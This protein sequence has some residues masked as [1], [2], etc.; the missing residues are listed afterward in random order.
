MSAGKKIQ[1]KPKAKT[2]PKITIHRGW[3]EALLVLLLVFVTYGNSIKN[4]YNL[5]DGYVVSLDEGN[6]QTMKGISGIPELLTTNY[7]NGPG[8]TYG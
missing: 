2:T 1:P 6:Q 5:D 8:V 3:W 4:D 7:S